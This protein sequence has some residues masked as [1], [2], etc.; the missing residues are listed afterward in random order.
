MDKVCLVCGK[1]LVKVSLGRYGFVFQCKECRLRYN[2]FLEPV[3]CEPMVKAFLLERKRLL[4]ELEVNGKA[5][6]TLLNG[7][8]ER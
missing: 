5:L 4:E 8:G 2:R 6:Q 7:G 1:P 3:D